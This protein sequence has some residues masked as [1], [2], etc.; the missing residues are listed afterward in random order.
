MTNQPPEPGTP[1]GEPTPYDIEPLGGKPV[2]DGGDAHAPDAGAAEAGAA[3][4]PFKPPPLLGD[5]D[6]DADFTKDPE[7]ERTLGAKGR[8]EKTAAEK[9]AARARARGG[10]AGAGMLTET[11]AADGEVF[12]RPGLGNLQVTGAIGLTLMVAAMV[13]SGIAARS[14]VVANIL[15]T[16]YLAVLHAGT[17]LAAVVIASHFAPKKVG[18]YE[19]AAAR[20]LVAVSA[21]LLMYSIPMRI[22]SSK[23][24]EIVCA[25]LV[26]VLAIFLYF[27][28]TARDTFI[29][30]AAHFGL[31]LIVWLGAILQV[32]S[33]A[34]TAA[35]AAGVTP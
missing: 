27:R 31:W 3:H 5:F 14:S 10:A 28:Q 32:A 4:E 17:G 22:T 21:F 19:L 26:Y 16:G 23:F 11:E 34:T 1:Q 29:L 12:T 30:A 24:E 6:E 15:V 20:M 18:R 13:A 9:A 2:H 33:S 8:A 25:A 7:V 35:P